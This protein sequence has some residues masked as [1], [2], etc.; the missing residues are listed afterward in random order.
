[1]IGNPA[2]NWVR[3]LMIV[4]FVLSRISASF[5]ASLEVWN[6]DVANLSKRAGERNEGSFVSVSPVAV[7]VESELTLSSCFEAVRRRSRAEADSVVLDLTLRDL[8]PS[9][10]QETWDLRFAGLVGL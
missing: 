3:A 6:A 8:I 5:L 10:H 4:S 1:M 7:S 2:A 9:T